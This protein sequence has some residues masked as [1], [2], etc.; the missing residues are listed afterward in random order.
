MIVSLPMYDRAETA[1]ANDALWQG[2]RAR[3]GYGPEALHRDIGLWEAWL[4]PDL[5]LSQ[6]CNLPYRLRLHGHVQL[7][8]SP[9]YELPGCPPGYYNSVLVARAD[10]DRALPQLAKRSVINQPHS[11]SGFGALWY[12]LADHGITPT[13]VGESGGHVRSAPMVA[14]GAGDLACIDALSWRLIKRHDPVAAQLREIDRTAPTPATP[15][16]TGAGTDLDA[17]RESLSGAIAGLA[18]EHREALSLQ[19]LAVLDEAAY[20]NLPNPPARDAA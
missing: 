8:G 14:E 11:Q 16:I 6:T 5:L 19:D 4:A 1:A 9:D 12:H 18:P 17:L 15:Y 7:V 10:D 2:V 20:L 3:L 13:I